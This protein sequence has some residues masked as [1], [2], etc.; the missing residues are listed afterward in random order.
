MLWV[1][2]TPIGNL[3]DITLRALRLLREADVVLAEDTRRTR[4]LLTHFDIGTPLEAFHAHSDDGRVTTLVRRLEGGATMVLVSDAGTPLVSDPG[5]RL[6]AA[7]RAARLPVSVAP[8]AS[9][10]LAA[11]AGAGLRAERFRFLGF[12]PR[13]GGKRGRFLDALAG[14]PAAQ[15]LYEAPGRTPALLRD[16]APRLGARRVALCREL[17]KLHEEFRV[18]TAA[19]LAESAEAA[20]DAIRGEVTLVIEADDAA[21]TPEPLD[22]TEL[23][24]FVRERLV[25]GQRPKA[26][27]K[28]LA[29]R[30][31]ISGSE[32]YARVEALRDRAP[33]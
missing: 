9:A 26:V 22:D 13:A 11:L 33:A 17:T 20:A 18:G 29:A 19:E 30:Q 32:A 27:A 12:P 25:A 8:G 5:I 3:E 31:G 14:D 21:G 4:K 6:V 7:A 24:A 28:A 2:A 10:V 16:L 15:V 23:E 1:V